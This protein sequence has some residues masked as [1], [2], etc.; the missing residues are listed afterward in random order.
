VDEWLNDLQRGEVSPI[1]IVSSE[2]PILVDRFVR[3]VRDAVVPPEARSFNYDI[4]EGK[5]HGSKIVAAASTLPMMAERRLV[6]VRDLAQLSAE[7]SAPL[8]AYMEAPSSFAVLLA[9]TS[10]LDKRLKL[11]AQAAK[12]GFLVVLEGP[13]NP[14]AWIRAEAKAQGAQLT[15]EAAVRLAEVVGADLSRLS[16]VVEQLGQYAAGRPITVD[17]VDDVVADTRERTVFELTD[18]IGV[19]DRGKA[20]AAVASLCDQ[21]DSALGI[22]AMLARYY[23]QLLQLHGLRGT[24]KPEL[25]RALGVP[26]FVVDKLVTHAR[27][28]PASVLDRSLL[29]IAQADRALKG[30]PDAQGFTGQQVKILGRAL[31]ERVILETIVAEITAP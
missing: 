14:S 5:V 18:A 22:I 9:L 17:D 10:K 21:R 29:R 27:R 28:L 20:L 23:R 4:L 15:S 7:D 2:H 19:G 31:A 3:A 11:Y 1:Y 24:P 16:M 25:A 12:R 30:D 13:K 26:P 6:F 8:V